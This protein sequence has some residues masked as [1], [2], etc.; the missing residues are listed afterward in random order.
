MQHEDKSIYEHIM[1]YSRRT[2]AINRRLVWMM[3]G[4]FFLACAAVCIVSWFAYSS[5]QA[6]L[7]IVS[8]R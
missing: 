4:L 1:E 5:V 7:T 2:D 8:G 3:G 6:A